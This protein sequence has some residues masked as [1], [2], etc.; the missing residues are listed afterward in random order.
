[1]A[2]SLAQKLRRIRRRYRKQ[3]AESWSLERTRDILRRQSAATM[4]AIKREQAE[5]QVEIERAI[6]EE[7]ERA[8]EP[9][10]GPEP[11]RLVPLGSAPMTPG[12]LQKKAEAASGGRRG[13]LLAVPPGISAAG[14]PPGSFIEYTADGSL[15]VGSVEADDW[16]A[17]S[18][19][20]VAVVTAGADVGYP[21]NQDYYFELA[22]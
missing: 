1:M 2:E 19:A 3:L 8:P 6:T 14:L 18:M 11:Q 20:I 5:T 4:R 15:I 10:A 12:E 21:L 9:K 16:H 22:P 17:V 13:R 7:A